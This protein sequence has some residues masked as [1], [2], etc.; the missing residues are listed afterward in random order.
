MSKNAS[1]QRDIYYRMA[2]ENGYRA[3]SAYKLLHCDEKYDLFNGVETVVDL[4]AAPGSWSQVLAEQVFFKRQREAENKKFKN[5]VN[6]A[7]RTIS[8]SLNISED[9]TGD[10]VIDESESTSDS[11]PSKGK[12]VSVDIQPMSAIDGVKII[13]GD[14]TTEETIREIIDALEGRKAD[15][16]VCDGAPDVTGM[17]AFDEY[18]Q[19]QLLYA[20][21]MTTVCVLKPGGSFVS[22]IF[23]SHNIDLIYSQMSH[24][25]KE[26]HCYKPPSSRP[27]SCEH[28]LV[29]KSYTPIPGFSACLQ[30]PVLSSNYA[31]T[32]A[33]L[34][35]VQRKYVP[36]LACGDTSGFDECLDEKDILKE[37]D[38]ILSV[39]K[40]TNGL[41]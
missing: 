12:V 41:L 9:K 25:F 26:V 31:E 20:A 39:E 32:L 5:E 36:Y 38:R 35:P 27:D 2:K 1:D 23:R 33:K 18:M 14:I 3:R 40:D 13:K 24:F 15:L 8:E 22:K 21:F 16:V 30:N 29:C 10:N 6:S 37:L 28:F 34:N 11:S 4:C 7:A 19:G 17:H